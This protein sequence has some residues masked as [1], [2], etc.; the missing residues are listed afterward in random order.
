MPAF[1]TVFLSLLSKPE[2]RTRMT[3]PSQSCRLRTFISLLLVVT[4]AVTM[5]LV[6]GI[7]LAY[8]IPRINSEAK[9]T[10]QRDAADKAKL[11]ELTLSS[12]E[13]Q[14]RPLVALT[15]FSTP[16]A[17]AITRSLQVLVGQGEQFVALYMVSSDGIVQNG[18]FSRANGSG[19][20][21]ARG[22]DLSRNPLFLAAQEGRSVWSD[23]YLSAQSGSYVIGVAQREGF[24]TIIG[25][26][27]PQYLRDSVSTVAGR[28]DNRVLVVDRTGEY[29][30]DSNNEYSPT[31]NLG[32]LPIA[33]ASRRSGFR[34]QRQA[35]ETGVDL[36]R[37]ATRR[38]GQP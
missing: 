17:V 2:Y 14:L 4:T 31:D 12:L 23:K 21:S 3:R 5:A 32:A 38:D 28:G 29:I 15:Q 1:V 16:D 19:S 9:E 27:S 37:D 22:G 11:L 26:I 30:A 10:V 35:R 8:R 13:S 6:G 18:R 20:S 25:E 34:R 33:Q 7:I 36:H 24:W